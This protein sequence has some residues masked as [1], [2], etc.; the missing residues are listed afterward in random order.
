M[1]GVAGVL[2][3]NGLPADSDLMA[4]ML[5]MIRH[6]GPDGAGLHVDGP[7]G[8]A[9]TRLSVI[10]MAG[11]HQ[12]M[13]HPKR[14]LW[15]TFNGEIFN[16]LELRDELMAKGHRF[17]THSDTE[18]ILHL[19]AEEGDACVERL[20]G[21][22]AFAIWDQERRRLFL[23]RDRLGVRPLFYAQ[24]QTAFVFASEIKAILCH[25]SVKRNLD[26]LALD[27]IFTFWFT[28]PPRTAFEGVHELPPGHSLVVEKGRTTV[29]P[30]WQL[31]YGLTSTASRWSE[32]EAGERLGE[33]LS[34]AT[35]LRLRADVPVGAY[36]SGGLDSTVTAAL[37]KTFVGAGLKTFSITFDDAE[38]DER[39]FQ[40]EAV[41][42]LKTDHQ[43]L[44]CTSKEIGRIFPDVIWHTEKPIL[45]TAPAPLFLLSRFVRESG[46]KVVVTGE[47]ADEVLGGYDIFKESKVRR[48]WA[49]NPASRWRPWLLKR[50]YPY[51]PGLQNQPEAYQKA[52]FQME[53]KDLANPFFSHLLRWKM[54]TML[55]YFF[56]KELKNAVQNHDP[57]AL[58]ERTLP[59]AYPT[60]DAF[61]QAQYLETAYLL[62]GYILS[63][64]G[65]R[66][67][68]GHA[69]E[70]RFP[71]LDHRVVE[72]AG[73]LPPRLKMKVLNEKYLLKLCM[74]HVVPK[75]ILNRPKQPYRAP[76]G[77]SFFGSQKLD[78]VDDLLSH[79]R[80]RRNG[81][82]DPEAVAKL[83]RKFR[84]TRAIGI[85]DNMAL[86]AILST[87]LLV[88]QFI[89]N[90][91]TKSKEALWTDLLRKKSAGSSLTIS[92]SE[93][94]G[95]LMETSLS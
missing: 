54:T 59:A 9:H 37:A 86:V 7:V 19:Y 73:A 14:D 85:K 34:E 20:N 69:V 62:P 61:C 3:F 81:L 77:K 76:E 93:K 33:L 22:W 10:D 79:E 17:R 48:F 88:D 72:F 64:Q 51:L 71:F 65:D 68:M 57:L 95:S 12:P 11:G 63:S 32:A 52:F 91:E 27:E 1:C 53:A 74:Q 47:G 84:E 31:P 46:Y 26:L 75:S 5:A 39:L 89:V 30:Y 60:W 55:K 4:T 56:S 40:E 78:Y 42:R 8:L 43:T 13:R 25:P 29:R 92:C 87:Q 36:L 82:F 44:H 28:L 35:K 83:V 16:Y 66:V 58:L 80:I 50:L 18:V 49:R 38:F 45:R 41:R 23:C 6:R 90:I 94:T 24:D 21:D 2:N 15:I 70:G 67:A